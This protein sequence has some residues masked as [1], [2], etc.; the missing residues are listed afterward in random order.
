MAEQQF[1]ELIK[2][3]DVIA[4]KV[5]QGAEHFWPLVVKQVYI[6][7]WVGLGSLL[8]MLTL[9]CI[10]GLIARRISINNRDED[11]VVCYLVAAGFFGIIAGVLLLGFLC[12]WLPSVLNPEYAALVS[13]LENVK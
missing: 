1:D 5:G 12:I 9:A 8:L 2:R 13:L 10:S 11:I 4:D 3:L 6:N 7:F